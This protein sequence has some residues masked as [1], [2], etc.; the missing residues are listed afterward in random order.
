MARWLFWILFAASVLG[1]V[2][3]Y[4]YDRTVSHAAGALAPVEPTLSVGSSAPAWTDAQGF[5]Y[6][7]LGRFAGRVVVVARKNYSMGDFAHLS[8]TDLAIVWGPLS[9]PAE[10]S[11]LTFEQFW[12]P[13]GARFV[14]PEIRHGSRL[15]SRPFAEVRDYLL[16]NLTHLHTIPANRGIASHLAGI[17]PGQV[18]R[19]A[20]TLVDVTSPGGLHYTSSLALHDL[21]CEIAWIEELALED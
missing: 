18:I 8:P 12:A 15:A 21:N 2:R 6:R 10:Y 7:P 5:R 4:L 14:A 3:W 17:R 9:D 11:Q 16:D 13:F 19:F 20:G 1:G